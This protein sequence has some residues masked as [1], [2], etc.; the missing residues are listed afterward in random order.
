MSLR[1]QKSGKTFFPPKQ[2]L[3]MCVLLKRKCYCATGETGGGCDSKIND[4]CG[5]LSLSVTH[6][7]LMEE[8]EEGRKKAEVNHRCTEIAS[9]QPSYVFPARQNGCS[10]GVTC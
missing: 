6:H 5:L 9:S 8:K 3:Q 1:R 10:W 7:T 2:L 4:L